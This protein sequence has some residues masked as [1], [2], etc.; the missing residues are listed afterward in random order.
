MALKDYAQP[1]T[2][3]GQN[4]GQV[5]I[6]EPPLAGTGNV[7]GYEDDGQ[8]INVPLTIADNVSVLSYYYASVELVPGTWTPMAVG[9]DLSLS[10]N[11]DQ[12]V[13]ELLNVAMALKPLRLLALVTPS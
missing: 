10:L 8:P 1:S 11:S 7:I 9:T 13:F 3:R 12:V 6:E 5:Y 2:A 4:G